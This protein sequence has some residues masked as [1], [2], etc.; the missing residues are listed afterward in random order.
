MGVGVGW[1]QG[2]MHGVGVGLEVKVWGIFFFFFFF[3]FF[4]RMTLYF[5]SNLGLGRG[6]CGYQPGVYVPLKALFLV[7][8]NI[9]E[10]NR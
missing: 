9:H 6:L 5:H 2:S 10:K 7:F 3:F 4:L 8:I 1:T